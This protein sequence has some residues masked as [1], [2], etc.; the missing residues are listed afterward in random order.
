MQTVNKN[1]ILGK[2]EEFSQERMENALK[3]KETH[4]VDVFSGKNYTEM[5]QALVGKTLK[6]GIKKRFQKVR[7][8]KRVSLKLDINIKDRE[9]EVRDPEEITSNDVKPK[10]KSNETEL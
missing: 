7:P 5:R 9:M 6:L 1:G 10:T 2:V 3:R 8:D 4:H